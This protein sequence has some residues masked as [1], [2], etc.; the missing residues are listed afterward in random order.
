[1][2]PKRRAEAADTAATS[3][4]YKS[5]MDEM[6]D[7]WICPITTELPLDPVMA[8]DGHTY[9]RS[10]IEELIRVQGAGLKSPITN[11]SMGRKLLPS[12]QARNTIEKLVR[13]GAI[14]GDK[15]EHWLQRLSDEELV[16]TT[17]QKA[18][19]GDVVA[20]Y[21]LN[22]WHT[23]GKHGLRE[24]IEAA[25][26]WTMK[27]AELRDVRCMQTAGWKMLI[28]SGTDKQPMRGGAFLVEAALGGSRSAAAFLGDY[29]YV[30]IYGYPKS[31][32]EAK[33]WYSRVASG[34]VDHVSQN[35]L[36]KAAE[37][38]QEADGD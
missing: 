23:F 18:E 37:R 22:V 7:E 15:A 34:T 24:D 30:G 2:P 21:T 14:G 9:E 29:Y 5:A 19:G 33:V 6:A 16:K 10:A 26:R 11:L 20:M 28:G 4:K 13:S 27:G 3:K 25:F 8:E 31:K 32:K 1:M 12:T 38:A 35:H 17:V 36:D